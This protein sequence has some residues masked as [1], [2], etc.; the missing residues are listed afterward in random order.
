MAGRGGAAVYTHL[1]LWFGGD[2]Y[3]GIGGSY[4]W[5]RGGRSG[6]GGGGGGGSSCGPHQLDSDGDAILTRAAVAPKGAAA[7]VASTR[8]DEAPAQ[9]GSCT[10]GGAWHLP[11]GEALAVARS[12]GLASRTEREAWRKEGRRP[13]NAPSTPEKIYKDGGWQGWGHWCGTGNT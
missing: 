6:G 9:A 5:C 8:A 13:P 4:R 12:L 10:K 7:A 1:V 2:A 11:F 3:E